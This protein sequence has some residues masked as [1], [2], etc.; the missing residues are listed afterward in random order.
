VYLTAYDYELSWQMSLP[1]NERKNIRERQREGIE[2]AK[3][4]DKMVEIK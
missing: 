1:E 4:R 2:A 3:L